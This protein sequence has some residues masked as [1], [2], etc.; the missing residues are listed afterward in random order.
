MYILGTYVSS[1]KISSTYVIYLHKLLVLGGSK[2]ERLQAITLDFG[3]KMFQ[4]SHELLQG[5]TISKIGFYLKGTVTLARVP[6][7]LRDVNI[8]EILKIDIFMA[9]T[10]RT[11]KKGDQM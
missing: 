7:M 9:V 8:G 4:N 1:T 10:T 5:I 11:N 2:N 6:R 3:R